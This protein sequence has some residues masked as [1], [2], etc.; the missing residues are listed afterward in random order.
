MAIGKLPDP[1]KQSAYLQDFLRLELQAHDI[2][3]VARQ[4]PALTLN[5]LTKINDTV[6]P[7]T[8]LDIRDLALVNMMFDGLLRS[9]EAGAVQ[10]KNI[11]FEKRSAFI[12]RS[13]TDQQGKGSYRFLS[14]TALSYISDYISEANFDKKKQQGK[15]F[16]DP[17]RINEGILFRGISPKGT[18]MLVHDESITRLSEMQKLDRKSIYRAIKRLG[19]K[20]HIDTSFSAHSP[21]VG[22]AVSLAES[23]ASTKEIQHTGGWKTAETPARYI[24]QAKIGSGMEDLAKKYKR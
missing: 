18:T 14:N 20:A 3:N 23:D 24:E 1:L 9:N 17:T 5:L 19:K 21:R 16:D 15:E 10:I 12:A 11:N 22:G 4:A 8:L 13:K 2:Y 6:I 7:N